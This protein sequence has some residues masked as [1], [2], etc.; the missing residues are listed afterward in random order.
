VDTGDAKKALSLEMGAEA[1]VDFKTSK[2]VAEEVKKIADGI[3]AHGVFVT[4]PA[5]YPTAVSLVG[6]R[7]GATIMCIGVS[8]SSDQ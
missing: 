4:G 1:F 5:A 7:V 6:D 2:D 3:G 8:Y